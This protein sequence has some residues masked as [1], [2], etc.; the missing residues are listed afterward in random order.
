MGRAKRI[1]LVK[2]L[3][4]VTASEDGSYVGD[5][6]SMYSGMGPDNYRNT[7]VFPKTYTRHQWD[8]LD[9]SWSASKHRYDADLA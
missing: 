9:R 8:R 4:T 3:W 6:G 1:Y 5:S 2:N 7:V